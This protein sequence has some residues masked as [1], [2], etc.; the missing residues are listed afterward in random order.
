MPQKLPNQ[1]VAEAITSLYES[2]YGEK[3]DEATDL[4]ELTKLIRSRLIDGDQM[5]R[6]TI[7][8][9]IAWFYMNH[10]SKL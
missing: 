4:T 9:G 1:Q 3:L 2:G 8:E 6:E 7:I 10:K 5:S